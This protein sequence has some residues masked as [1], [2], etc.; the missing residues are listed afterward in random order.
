MINFGA[1]GSEDDIWRI[2]DACEGA[3]IFGIPS[4]VKTSASGFALAQIFLKSGFGGLVL[5][6]KPEEPS[7]WV[8][9]CQRFGRADDCVIVGPGS[10][11]KLNVLAYE[12]Q[13]PDAR[14]GLASDMVAVFRNLI[15]VVSGGPANI[16]KDPFWKEAVDN[17]LGQ[18]FTAFLLA[19]EP[20]SIHSLSRFL[21]K[22][23][24]HP[25][26]NWR[27]IE[28]FGRIMETAEQRAKSP[29]DVEDF[30][31][32][33]DYWTDQ[34][35]AIPDV[36]RTGIETAF[37]SMA[38]M[39][40]GHRNTR[41]DCRRNRPDSRI[42]SFRQDR[43]SRPSPQRKWGKGRGVNS[44]QRGSFYSSAPLNAGPTRDER[45]PEPGFL[46]E[47]EGHLT[48]S[49]HDPDFQPT[50]RDC[51][52]AHVVLSQNLHNFFQLGHSPDAVKAVF[53]SMNTHI[54]H[55][56]S[57]LET[58]KW[59]SER[60]GTVMRKKV[61]VS[62]SSE[63]KKQSKTWFGQ[64]FD[65]QYRGS[66][67]SA[68]VEEHETRAFKPE[69]FSALKKAGDGSCEALI[70]WASHQFKNNHGRPYCCKTFDQDPEY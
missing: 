50:C 61:N 70:L 66:K 68:S 48:F 43:D 2:R 23:P 56:N 64:A 53:S 41:N 19:G 28:V 38:A 39:L 63:P 30:W 36:T 29:A 37:R 31:E 15:T 4:S 51:R 46:W 22:A 49:S 14:I 3:L 45:L 62:I 67:S 59:A 25:T 65:D 10:P 32:C 52:A 44:G 20:L 1:D 42:H 34:F 35:P 55:A 58:N 11:H 17:L 16:P 6:A 69:S 9:L 57:D 7:R 5:T 60:V 12:S 54:F 26:A 24:R 21:T 40:G 27:S 18:M 33:F 8:R 13:R 47:D